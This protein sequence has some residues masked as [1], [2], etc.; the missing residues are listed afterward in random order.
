MR[1]TSKSAP[2]WWWRTE[3]HLCRLIVIVQV[4]SWFAIFSTIFNHKGVFF[5]RKSVRNKNEEFT[6]FI[7]LPETLQTTSERFIEFSTFNPI[8]PRQ[9]AHTTPKLSCL[10]EGLKMFIKYFFDIQLQYTTLKLQLQK[11]HTSFRQFLFD[12]TYLLAI[13]D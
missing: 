2:E 13:F 12:F 3:E 11:R 4:F 5:A 7:F 6:F 10:D 9:S 1:L 8:R